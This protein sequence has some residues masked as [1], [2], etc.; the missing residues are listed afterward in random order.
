LNFDVLPQLWVWLS[1]TVAAERLRDAILH[2]SPV[3]IQGSSVNPDV[4]TSFDVSPH[5]E[6]TFAMVALSQQHFVLLAQPFVARCAIRQQ[7]SFFAAFVFWT[8]S[9]HSVRSGNAAL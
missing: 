3:G 7:Q 1:C 6:D 8:N 2:Q 4:S 9:I 5:T